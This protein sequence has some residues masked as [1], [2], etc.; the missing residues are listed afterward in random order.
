MAFTPRTFSEILDEMI[1]HVQRFTTISDFTP[2]SV[3]R[4]MLEACALEDD[5]QYFQMV[6][7]LDMFSIASAT[8]NDLDRR[9][10][11][12]G[13]TRFAPRAA[14]GK[15]RFFDNNLIQNSVSQD[16][17]VGA[18]TVVVF[19]SIQFPA[20]GFPYE[21]RI[22]E[23]TSRVMNVLVTANNVTTGE[24]TLSAGTPYAV[25]VNNALGE[26]DRVSLVTGSVDRNVGI[27]VQVQSPPTNVESVK[28]YTTQEQG[29]IVGGNFFSNEVAIQANSTGIGSNVAVNSITQFVASPSFTGAGV[30]NSGTAV[31]GGRIRETDDNF[32]TRGLNS[33][34]SLS[35]G[36]PLALKTFSLGVEDAVTGQVVTFASVQEDFITN[37]VIVYV[38]DGAG[39]A[40]DTTAY[41]TETLLGPGS[42]VAISSPTLDL[43]DASLF[44]SAGY[45]LIQAEGVNLAELIEY[46]SK[47]GNTLNLATNTTSIHASGAG[48]G[49]LVSQVAILEQSTEAGQRRFRVTNAPITS[50]TVELS[51]LEPGSVWTTLVKDTDYV[52]DRG[53]GEIQISDLGGLP[54]LT[55]VV[56]N[57][58]YHTNLIARVQKVLEGDP[59]NSQNFP[60]VKAAGIRLVV[61]VPSKSPI[62]VQANISAKEG[63]IEEDLAPLVIQ[64]IEAYIGDLGI[65]GNVI[66]SKIIDVAFNVVG[67]RDI[68]V[69]TPVANVTIFEDQL[70]TPY[71]NNGNSLVT[72]T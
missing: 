35:R 46:T 13:L 69:V 31:S 14:T 1:A 8:G 36:T 52:L 60:G 47:T 10:A 49:A 17:L 22:A 40:A 41:D 20:T 63:F 33:I 26:G 61:E 67:V 42:P 29:F 72:V 44:P 57:Y 45:V 39:F 66:V 23:G 32:R 4:T 53:T 6:Q 38:D 62:V 3:I 24:L 64:N 2:G 37:E 9:M 51:V 27:G 25:L 12:F 15:V 5:E 50:G 11:D 7:L 68:N 71:D 28:L 43:G 19:D 18:T 70:P 65:G 59:T 34:Q 21:I 48:S 30:I 58:S 54:A 56:I 55:Q 16:A